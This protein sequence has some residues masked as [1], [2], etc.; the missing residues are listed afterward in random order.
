MKK[1]HTFLLSALIMVAGVTLFACG[2]GDQPKSYNITVEGNELV[3]ISTDF[4]LAQE[5]TLITVTVE[6]EIDVYVLN[7]YANN[8]TCTKVDDNTYTFTLVSDTTVSVETE[9]RY[10][11]VSESEYASEDMLNP[12]QIIKTDASYLQGWRPY[13][14]YNFSE[15]IYDGDNLKTLI[16][17]NQDVIPNEALS[18][19]FFNSAGRDNAMVDGVNVYINTDMIDYG[20]TY[21]VLEFKE[22]QVSS[23]PTCRLV[24]RIEVISEENY[25]YSSD[26]MTETVTLNFSSVQTI[27]D[28]FEYVGIQIS[29]D[30]NARVYGINY[31]EL[32]ISLENDGPVGITEW[33]NTSGVI[34]Y[35]PKEDLPIELTIN[36][37]YLAGHHFGLDVFGL[38]KVYPDDYER[39]NLSINERLSGGAMYSGGALTFERD[40]SSLSLDVVSR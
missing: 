4:Q 39:I 23:S 25:D 10:Q 26:L 1:L 29:D 6:P 8:E 9:M 28:N 2:S 13:L 12:T 5:G 30:D 18:A 27:L 22:S 33:W 38:M 15:S 24:K 20:E 14:T 3:D 40:N 7:V 37:G 17:S 36:F 31:G 35:I 16:S 19:E 21:I 11:E 32:G 34:Y